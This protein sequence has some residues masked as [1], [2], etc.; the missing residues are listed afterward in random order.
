MK[1]ISYNLDEIKYKYSVNSKKWEFVLNNFT[2]LAACRGANKA[3]RVARQVSGSFKRSGTMDNLA[4]G[5]I[6]RILA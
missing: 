1:E 5:Q 6:A 3:H 2:Y 4:R